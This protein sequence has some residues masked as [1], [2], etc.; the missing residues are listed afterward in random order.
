MKRVRLKIIVN[1][2]LIFIYTTT[3]NKQVL[4]L[5][6]ISLLVTD[7]SARVSLIWEEGG[8]PLRTHV[9][10]GD[11]ISVAA[12]RSECIVHYATWTHIAVTLHMLKE[13]NCAPPPSG[14]CHHFLQNGKYSVNPYS[15]DQNPPTPE[16][17]IRQGRVQN[18]SVLKYFKIPSLFSF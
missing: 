12:V 5:I 16:A 7:V 14:P 8:V 6:L 4:H 18:N 2:N 9:S 17:T 3:I 10:K 11:Q 13:I 15:I 1:L